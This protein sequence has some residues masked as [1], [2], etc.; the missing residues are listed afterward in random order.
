MIHKLANKKRGDSSH[1]VLS[2][3]IGSSR[4][5]GLKVTLKT[6]GMDFDDEYMNDLSYLYSTVIVLRTTY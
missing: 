3:F 1:S 2:Y 4:N 6:S 5:M